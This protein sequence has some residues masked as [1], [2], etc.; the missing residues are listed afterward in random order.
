MTIEPWFIPAV[1]ALLLW[2]AAGFL[3]KV[4]LRHLPPMELVVYQALFFLS[5][6]LLSRIFYGMPAFS[7][8]GMAVA[9]ATGAIGTLGQMFLLLS[10]KRGPLSKVTIVASLYPGVALLLAFLFLHEPLTHKQMAGVVL[11]F[12][13]ILLLV[14]E[15]EKKHDAKI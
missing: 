15:R 4:T 10:L 3:S 12:L 2:G 6:T 1:I 14:I 11:G 8:H 13:S 9:M 5:F 7:I